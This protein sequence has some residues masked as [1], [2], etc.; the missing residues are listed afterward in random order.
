MKRSLYRL[1]R[2]CSNRRHRGSD[3]GIALLLALWII[4]LL[5][6]VCAEF[7]WT[8]RTELATAQ[9]FRDGEQ[10]YYAAEA[11][12][13]RALIELMRNASWPQQQE[14]AFPEARERDE[15]LPW[16]P[17][18]RHHVAF[19]D[20]R[21]EV[22]IE[23]ESNKI[24]INT[25]LENAK[26]NPASL[27]ELLKKTFKLEGEQLDV[28]AD[29]LIDWYDKDD[30]ITGV[31]GTESEYYQSLEPPYRCRNGPVPV[32]EELLLVR[33]ID[34]ALFFGPLRPEMHE[35][36]TQLTREELDN[37]LAGAGDR[38]QK[39]HG[40]TR[41]PVPGL[42]DIFCA[43]NPE[44]LSLAR[45]SPATTLKID[46]NT[47]TLQQ[48]L[49]L[50][51]MTLA[52]AQQII[53]ERQVRRFSGTNDPRLAGM[54]MYEVWKN[55]ITASARKTHGLYRITATGYADDGR[56][57]RCIACTAVIKA[58]SCFVTSWKALN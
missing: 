41:E 12:I 16:E 42:V 27:K 40:E 37:L 25:V 54:A 19:A 49:V 8:M 29:S 10:A 18:V 51:G 57:S 15:S 21:C 38:E 11:G 30:N 46:V 47:A 24:E 36:K 2:I 9:N 52:T 6:V 50:D 44:L 13:N 17:G 43:A 35:Q 20:A 56:V 1:C 31:N 7:S 34:E 5:A 23:D 3:Q 39:E 53:D 48:L 28:V 45:I 58:T 22:L 55:Q 4:T 32:I 14:T 26:K 33:G